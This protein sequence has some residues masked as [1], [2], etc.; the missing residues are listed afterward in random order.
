[1]FRSGYRAI[2]LS[3][4]EIIEGCQESYM[5]HEKNPHTHTHTYTHHNI[6][7]Y[8]NDDGPMETISSQTSYA[9]PL[10]KKGCGV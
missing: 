8:V 4:G 3:T 5:L 2:P 9:A 1:M 6:C 7:F 10:D